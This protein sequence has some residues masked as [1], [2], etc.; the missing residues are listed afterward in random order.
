MANSSKSIK[1]ITKSLLLAQKEIEN[2]KKDGVNPHFKSK[3]STLEESLVVCKFALNKHGLILM[4]PS[5]VIEIAGLVVDVIETTLIH[6]ESGEY[7]KSEYRVVTG[8]EGPQ[9]FGAAVT[10]ARRYSLLGLLGLV[11]EDDDGNSAMKSMPAQK[12]TQKPVFQSDRNFTESYVFQN[13]EL[14]GQVLSKIN[15][16]EAL[17]FVRNHEKTPPLLKELV[18]KRISNL[19]PK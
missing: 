5:R 7:I 3:Y 11:A 1:E 16:I 6:A 12:P 8:K 18:D 19:S 10:Y 17:T 2:P 14:A 9:G 13:G 4:Q 15:N